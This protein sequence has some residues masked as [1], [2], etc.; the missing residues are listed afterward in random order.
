MSVGEGLEGKWSV[1]D[2]VFGMAFR[3]TGNGTFSEYV[4]VAATDPIARKPRE[5]SFEQAAAVPLVVLTAF[6]V[7]EWLPKEDRRN[8]NG[9]GKRRVVVAGASGGTGMWCV[10]L[11]KKLF[12]CHVTAVCSGK[13]GD[14]VRRMGADEV[15]DYTSHDVAQTLLKSVEK[16]GKYDLYIDC[17]GGAEIFEHWTFLLHSYGAYVTIVGDKTSRTT[18]GGAMTYLTSPTQV[19]RYLLGFIRGPRYAVIEFKEK[20]EWLQK[21]ATLAEEQEVEVVVQEVIKD[22]LKEGSDAWRRVFTLMEEG[23]VKGKI[24]VGID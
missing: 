12:D 9:N 13:N 18:V 22:V 17:V 10:Q 8:G 16:D 6:A 20:S 5:W 24:V 19:F 7:L 4:T 2:E 1:G 21:V 11:A 15:V 3:V 23:R 14:F